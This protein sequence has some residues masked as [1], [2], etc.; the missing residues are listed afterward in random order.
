MKIAVLEPLGIPQEELAE[1]LRRAV[2]E[3][4]EIVCYDTRREDEATLVERSR[5]ADAVVLT[6]FCYPAEV[7]AQC[8]KLRLIC[9]AFTGCDHVDTAFCRERGIRVSNC[10][11][12]S[13]A[14]VAELAIG[15]AI[16]L[17]RRILPCGEA[18]RGGGTRAGLEGTE[19][20]GKKFGVVGAGAIGLRVAALACAFGCEVYAASRTP[21]E[22]PGVRFT[23]L[24][25]L[26][27]RCDLVSLH[28]PLTDATRGMIGRERL[29]R[30]KPGAVLINT[31]RGPVVDAAALAEALNAGRLAGAG[32]DVFDAEP[33][34]DPAHPLLHAKNCVLTPHVGFA[35]REAMA[36]RAR[37]VCENLSAWLDGSPRNVVI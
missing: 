11:G 8:P 10:A 23:D 26:L 27:A 33:P 17:Y 3:R 9:V 16:A 14:A 18:A 29:A 37:I 32:V 1:M 25:T 7:I 24:D 5:D 21:K 13:T 15:L 35:T 19:L 30:M 4:A 12:Y 28:V 6:N 20:A 36:R 34:L 2:G 22:V 31:S